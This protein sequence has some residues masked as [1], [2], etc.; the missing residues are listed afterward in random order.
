M[1]KSQPCY[2]N[3][4][5]LSTID[6]ILTNRKH[7]FQNTTALEVG[8]SDLHKLILTILNAHF[9]K[10]KPKIITYHDYKKFS[11]ITFHKK[12]KQGTKTVTSYN[13][14]ENIFSEILNKHAPCKTKYVRANESV[15]MDRNIK[16]EIMIRSKLKN[17]YLNNNMLDNHLAYKR[18]Q[19]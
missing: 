9:Q 4:E 18:Q 17:K 15:F 19:N 3:S 10:A 5:N 13:E 11:D 6:L 16:K 7:S 2:K 14:F 1:L 12:L 8:I